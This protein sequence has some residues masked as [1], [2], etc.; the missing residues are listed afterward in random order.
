MKRGIRVAV[1]PI[2]GRARA[3]P[4]L[5]KPHP[6]SVMSALDKL[7]EPASAAVLVGDSRTDMEVSVATGVLGIGFA[8]KQGKSEVLRSAGAAVI[9]AGPD[10]MALLVDAMGLIH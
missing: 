3:R 9:V 7:G 10:G 8:N 1:G 5:M 4:D 2:V 6:W